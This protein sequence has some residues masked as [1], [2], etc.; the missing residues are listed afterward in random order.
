MG[1][2]GIG[3]GGGFSLLVDGVVSRGLGF[4]GAR[5]HAFSNM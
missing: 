3:V 2:A 5:Y 1:V 4:F